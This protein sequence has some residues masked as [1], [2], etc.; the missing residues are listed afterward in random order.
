MTIYPDGLPGFDRL[1]RA[2]H[3]GGT[4]DI[5]ALRPGRK[6]MGR[7]GARLR[8]AFL[9]GSGAS[10]A[11]APIGEA[12]G[13]SVAVGVEAEWGIISAAKNRAI[14]R[15]ELKAKRAEYATA[16]LPCALVFISEFL[17]YG[18]RQ[19]TVYLCIDPFLDGL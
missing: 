4:A 16:D 13:P 11:T 17:S 9:P 14:I 12:L 18:L 7:D 2:G 3:S 6:R 10:G 8:A 19:V 5:K 1:D 15:L